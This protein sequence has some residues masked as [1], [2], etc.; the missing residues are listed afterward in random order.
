MYKKSKI[1]FYDGKGAVPLYLCFLCMGIVFCLLAFRGYIRVYILQDAARAE[2]VTDGSYLFSKRPGSEN[3]YINYS[4]QADGR[5]FVARS[6]MF[7]DGN[8]R[9][10]QLMC[11]KIMMQNDLGIFSIPYDKID[12][13]KQLLVEYYESNQAD[14]LKQFFRE[15]C[16]LR[17]PAPQG[18]K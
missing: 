10:A 7:L 1:Q 2:A 8:K 6:Q 14:N 3:K 13:F 17:N 4:F 5:S 9:V 15:K 16:L 18:K 11:N 12:T